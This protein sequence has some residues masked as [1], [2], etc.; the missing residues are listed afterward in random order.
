M[1]STLTKLQIVNNAMNSIGERSLSA[2]S[3]ILGNM[4]ESSLRE[5]I[6]FVCNQNEWRELYSVVNADSWSAQR[7]TMPLRT[8]RVRE[9]FWYTSPDGAA[10]AAY[11]YPKSLIPFT[12]IQEFEQE[13]LY[14]FDDN[15]ARPLNWARE[16]EDIVV[17]NPYPTNTLARSKVFFG[18]YRYPVL[19]TA[20]TDTFSTSDL[21]TNL[22][23]YKTAELLAVKHLGDMELAAAMNKIYLEFFNQH[24]LSDGGVPS[25]NMFRGRRGGFYATRR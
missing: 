24:Q 19:P 18:V 25:L 13:T 11:D 3:G 2:V 5:A 15:A 17:V 22:I 10:E 16:T 4:A 1:A 9:V 8:Y 21:L 20:D 6:F 12:T 23:Q 7:A 14:P